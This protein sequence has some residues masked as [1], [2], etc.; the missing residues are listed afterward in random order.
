MLTITTILF[1]Y[2]NSGVNLFI[3]VFFS[4]KLRRLMYNIILCKGKQHPNYNNYNNSSSRTR[5]T[6]AS[7]TTCV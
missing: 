5:K 1:L 3:Y 7:K 4:K 6:R 2:M